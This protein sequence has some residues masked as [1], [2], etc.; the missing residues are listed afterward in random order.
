M[1]TT[2]DIRNLTSLS[3]EAR[4]AAISAFDA[5]GQWRGEISSANDRYLTKA[6][7]QMAVA[8][9]AMGWPDHIT[10]GAREHLLQA[11]KMQAQTIDQVMNA[12]EQQ[13]KASNASSGVPEGLRFQSPPFS[14]SAFTDSMSEMMRL[15]EMTFAPFK[16]WMQVAEMWQQNWAAIMSGSAEPR[17]SRPI[18]KAA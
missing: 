16:L 7:D 5:L 9:R 1:M 6:L 4:Q 15:G 8:Q 13:L 17:P 2:S 3:N 12:W 11:S 18:R 14:G 10:A